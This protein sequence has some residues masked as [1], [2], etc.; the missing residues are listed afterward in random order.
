[1]FLTM[2][3]EAIAVNHMMNGQGHPTPEKPLEQPHASQENAIDGL[4]HEA[5]FLIIIR[6]H[7]SLLS[8][9]DERFQP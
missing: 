1:M 4:Q 2:C 6:I 9:C 7:H 3:E 5:D 8:H